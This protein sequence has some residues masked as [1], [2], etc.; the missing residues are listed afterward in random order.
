[1]TIKQKTKIR[2][3]RTSRQITYTHILVK[4]FVFAWDFSF[5]GSSNGQLGTPKS[6]SRHLRGHQPNETNW[7]TDSWLAELLSDIPSETI[8]TKQ[9]EKCELNWGK[10]IDGKR[11]R[12]SV[13]WKC[14]KIGNHY[15]LGYFVTGSQREWPCEHVFLKKRA[16]VNRY[17]PLLS[18]SS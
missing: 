15:G 16:N 9:E 12:I 1:M 17:S 13:A 8:Q 14:N 11:M 6:P 10:Q 3:A 5:P 7:T 2:L 18:H 4:N